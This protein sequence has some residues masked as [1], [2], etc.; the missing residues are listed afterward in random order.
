VMP[1]LH[2]QFGYVGFWVV[3]I[4]GAVVML[5]VFKRQGWI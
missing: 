5:A 2:Y 3:C 4:G 1:E